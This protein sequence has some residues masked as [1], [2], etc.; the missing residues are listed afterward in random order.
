MNYCVC[1]IIC[2]KLEYLARVPYICVILF[3]TYLLSDGCKCVIALFVVFNHR[4]NKAVKLIFCG[5]KC[6]DSF[7]FCFHVNY[8]ASD[9]LFVPLNSLINILSKV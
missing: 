9:V 2:F 4:H 5:V 8:E 3:I 7:V 6:V 1:A